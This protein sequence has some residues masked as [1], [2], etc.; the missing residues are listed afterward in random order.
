[1]TPENDHNR[2]CMNKTP[3]GASLQMC[4]SEVQHT[5]LRKRGP[6]SSMKQSY[7]NI[8]LTFKKCSI[9]IN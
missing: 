8:V 9:I 3:V 1:M 7:I 6:L 5:D 2:L 4:R